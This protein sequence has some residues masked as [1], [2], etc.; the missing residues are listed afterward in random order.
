LAR[1]LQEQFFQ[2]FWE[3]PRN[4]GKIMVLNL[5]QQPESRF[6]YCYYLVN[7]ITLVLHQAASTVLSLHLIVVH[8]KAVV[9][10]LLFFNLLN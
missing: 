6:G 9:T 8:N 10:Q 7:V 2:E 3:L 1:R 5:K 4:G